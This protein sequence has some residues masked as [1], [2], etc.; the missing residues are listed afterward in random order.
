[1][2]RNKYFSPGDIIREMGISYQEGMKY[3]MELQKKDIIRKTKISTYYTL[4]DKYK[5]S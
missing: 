1:M 2:N 3:F 4:N 5:K